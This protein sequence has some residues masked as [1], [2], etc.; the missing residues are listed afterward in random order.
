MPKLLDQ[1]GENKSKNLRVLR[2]FVSIFCREK[3]KAKSKNDFSLEDTKLSNTSS[4]WNKMLCRDCHKLLRHG[5]AKLH[6]CPY[7]PKPMCKKCPTHCYS[8]GYRQRM[9]EVMRFS[10][11]YL[12]KRGRLD[13][14]F[15]YLF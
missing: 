15:H 10:G 9:R 5:I 4:N 1:M 7:N 13:L 8:P 11:I 3:H 6:L 12:I 2:D 14:L